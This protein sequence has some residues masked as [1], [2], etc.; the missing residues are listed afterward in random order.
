MRKFL[1][2]GLGTFGSHLARRLA[3][4]GCEVVGIDR[5][6]DVVEDL[7]DALAQIHM[8]DVTDRKALESLGVREFD[9]AAVSLGDRMDSAILSAMY[10]KELGAKRVV[11][12]AVT[13][14]HAKILR[15]VG[16]DEV[17]FPERDMALRLAARLTWPNVL[18]D[19]RL[20]PGYSILELAPTVELVGK[21]LGESRMR[22][23]YNVHVIA[24]RE[25]VPERLTVAPGADFVV[26]DSDIL[27]VLGRDEDLEKIRRR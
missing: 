11:A 5:S 26:K 18:E 9:A 8:F 23:R 25:L 19:L 6:Q 17:V 15:H 12:K 10:L 20:A 21:S 16:A 4:N 22:N 24:V 3:E 27:V 14:D 7:R 13:M 2:L 1:I